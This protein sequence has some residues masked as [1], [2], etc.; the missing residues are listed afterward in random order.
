MVLTARKE[1]SDPATADQYFPA[2][3]RLK[4]SWLMRDPF[5]TAENSV[6][7]RKTPTIT[8]WKDTYTGLERV[9]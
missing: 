6:E 4:Q 5:N 8:D 2:N 7:D 3:Y 9:Y 1:R